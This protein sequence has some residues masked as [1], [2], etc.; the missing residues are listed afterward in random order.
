MKSRTP[1]ILVALLWIALLSYACV[2]PSGTA[3][4]TPK[5][6]VPAGYSALLRYRGD[7][8]SAAGDCSACHTRLKSPSGQD[9]SIDSDWRASMMANAA[10][11][12][13]YR[14]SVRSEVEDNP[15]YAQEIEEKCATCH[16]PMALTT[17]Q[18]NN[19]I[20][21]L[22]PPNGYLDPAHPYHLLAQDGVSC[23]HCHQIDPQ[24]LGQEES[25]SG[26]FDLEANY[27]EGE[28]PAFG[29]I[30]TD[31]AA[32]NVMQTASGFVPKTA[33]HLLSAEFCATCHNLFTP[34]LDEQGLL[35]EEMFPEQT[36]HLEWLHSSYA[37]SQSCQVCH[38]PQV[39]GGAPAANT[40]TPN[41][42]SFYQHT[43]SGANY[44]MIGM[45][46]ENPEALQVTAGPEHFGLAEERNRQMLS[47]QTAEL[48]TEAHLVDG[49]LIVDVAI[50]PLTG[51]KFPTSYPSRR[52][53]LHVTVTDEQQVVLFESGGW[54]E[55]GRIEGNDNDEDPRSYEPHYQQITASDQVQIYEVIILSP[56][57][58]VTTQLMQAQRYL[59]DNRLLPTGFDKASAAPEIAV[60][61][62]AANDPDFA[63]G[64]DRIRYEIELPQPSSSYQ[65][66]VELLYQPV[67]YRWA[68]NL[69]AD[70]T[71]E[72]IEFFSYLDPLGIP[73]QVVSYSEISLQP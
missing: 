9:V 52:A 63:A 51:H 32:E 12:P 22:L 53:W 59:K 39:D 18:F 48:K 1:T 14:A 11:D 24:N 49:K 34:I 3:T 73:P 33:D 19:E 16:V 40:G 71:P 69:R 46:N 67:G 61:G 64:E 23:T 68:E 31:P 62:E 44:W 10:R 4:P 65:V 21:A 17:S 47:E 20:A 72:S 38:V 55:N 43:F 30:D 50:H 56:G 45:L 29:H 70:K 36:P 58:E 60:N 35:T 13:Y 7:F 15:Q 6:A 66:R 37:Q 54:E 5:P 27:A 57:G 8:F 28:R 26:G 42:P 2:R 41:R 25:F